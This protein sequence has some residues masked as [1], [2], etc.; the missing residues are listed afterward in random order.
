MNVLL[1]IPPMADLNTPYPSTAYLTGY[2]RSRGIATRQVD[3][4]LE[5]ACRLFS[6]VGLDRLHSAVTATYD[7][8]TG[9]TQAVESFLKHFEQYRATVESAVRFL[10]GKDLSIDER[11]ASRQLLPEGPRFATDT[12]CEAWES[13]L[14]GAFGNLGIYDRAKYI[15]SLFLLDISDVVTAIDPLFRLSIDS[16]HP[17]IRSTNCCT[18]SAATT[19]SWGSSLMKSRETALGNLSR[20]LSPCLSH[21]RGTY[22][23]RSESPSASGERIRLSRLRWGEVLQIPNSDRSRTRGFSISLISSHSTTANVR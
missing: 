23:A 21:F 4:S 15:A 8:H 1:V 18:L 6:R 17:N 5:L 3:W 2:L 13:T 16:Q 22:L 10:Q 20:I 14:V 9:S 7:S 19:H 11:I 12:P